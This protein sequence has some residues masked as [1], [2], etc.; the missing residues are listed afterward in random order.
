MARSLLI[1]PKRLKSKYLDL[2]YLRK[3]RPLAAGESGEEKNLRNL[4]IKGQFK[5]LCLINGYRR[6]ERNPELISPIPYP[7]VNKPAH[8]SREFSAA[9][10]LCF[11]F[12]AECRAKYK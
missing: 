8:S 9:Y 7:H 6:Y 12:C 1:L 5:K 4:K 11:E 3:S 2:K 10:F